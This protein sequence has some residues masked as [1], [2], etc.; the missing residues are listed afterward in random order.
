[1]VPHGRS[2]AGPGLFCFLIISSVLT[3]L[4]LGPFFNLSMNMSG[5][6]SGT[7]SLVV[8]SDSGSNGK[9]DGGDQIC[10]VMEYGSLVMRL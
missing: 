3:S 2:P 7:G 6:T 9:A 4:L 10:V 5:C 8:G 1:M